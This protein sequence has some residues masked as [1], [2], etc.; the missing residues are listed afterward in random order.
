[1][2][3]SF[4]IFSGIK[5]VAKR[6]LQPLYH[7]DFVWNLTEYA[8]RLRKYNQFGR[9]LFGKVSNSSKEHDFKYFTMTFT[10][11]I[12]HMNCIQIINE[13]AHSDNEGLSFLERLLDVS[14]KN[15]NFTSEDVLAETATI[16]TGV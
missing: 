1:M 7:I 12:N 8:Q 3:L 11:T 10:F 13:K 14:K 15:P 2:N 16:L 9:E 6:V 5:I 4:N